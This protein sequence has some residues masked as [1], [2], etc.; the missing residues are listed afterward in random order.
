MDR[1][2]TSV[3]VLSTH[4]VA[5]GIPLEVLL[6]SG[7]REETILNGLELLKSILPNDV[8]FGNGP[9][10]GPNVVLIDDST[11]ERGAITKCWPKTCVLLCTFHFLQWKWI[12]L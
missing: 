1:F 3:F 9:E 6:T 7:E 8:F 2:N 10:T 11:A 5:S 4:S 12:W